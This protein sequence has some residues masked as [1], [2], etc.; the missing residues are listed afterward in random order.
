VALACAFRIPAEG[1]AVAG[2]AADLVGAA[3]VFFAAERVG[4]MVFFWVAWADVALA[5]VFVVGLCPCFSEPAF[6]SWAGFI[7]LAL[8]SAAGAAATAVFSTT[9]LRVFF[10]GSTEMASGRA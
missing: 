8:A 4:T 2:F 7:A 9:L 5:E 3:T 1:F 10:R 6:F